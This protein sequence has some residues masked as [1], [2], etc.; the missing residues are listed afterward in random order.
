[1][2]EWDAPFVF[3]FYSTIST[4]PKTQQ[5]CLC[6]TQ[7]GAEFHLPRCLEVGGPEQTGKVGPGN[8]QWWLQ[9]ALCPQQLSHGPRGGGSHGSGLPCSS[10]DSLRWP[11]GS[12]PGPRP[13]SHRGAHNSSPH[14]SRHGSKALRPCNTRLVRDGPVTPAPVHPPLSCESS[15]WGCTWPRAH[16]PGARAVTLA[17]AAVQGTPPPEAREQPGGCGATP[18]TRQQRVGT[19]GSQR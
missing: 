11:G 16:Y 14:T 1:M 3:L 10:T 12:G 5:R 7:P 4:T 19:S 2:V 13:P 17:T 8:T 15:A 6:S 9:S 18:L